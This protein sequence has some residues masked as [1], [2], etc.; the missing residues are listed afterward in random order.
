MSKLF[1]TLRAFIGA[2]EFCLHASTPPEALPHGNRQAD[3]ATLL[4]LHWALPGG[5]RN[6]DHYATT[7]QLRDIALRRGEKF[8]IKDLDGVGVRAVSVTW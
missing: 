4:S 1:R 6:A 7:E 2:Q 5:P 8:C 3:H